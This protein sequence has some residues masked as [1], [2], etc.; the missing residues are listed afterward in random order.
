[1]ERYLYLILDLFSFAIPF[2]YSFERKRIHF[3]KYWKAYFSAIIS[4]GLFFIIWDIFFAY[5]NI[6]GFNERYLVG[7]S[8]FKLPL[9]EWLF[10]LLI[11][12]ASNFIH[13]AL[14]Y[15]FPKPKISNYASNLISWILFII[16]FSVAI[17]NYDK[18]YTLCSFGLFAILMLLQSLFKFPYLSRYLLS[19]IIIFIPF[20]IVNS[21]LTGSFTAEPI[22]FYNNSENLGIRLG[23]IP[24]EDCFYCFSLLYSSVLL[25]EFFK[26]KYYEN[27]ELQ[28]SS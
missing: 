14:L 23:T 19:F 25:F 11:P 5:Q 20:L 6:W 8:L 13:Y 21:W 27:P 22:V 3:I 17:F 18:L 2:L 7:F 4:V 16:S 24:V 12:Y 9:E 26:I 10:F 1:M 15:F 28:K